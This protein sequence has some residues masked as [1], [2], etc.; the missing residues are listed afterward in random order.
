VDLKSRP[1]TNGRSFLSST[2]GWLPGGGETPSPEDKLGPLGLNTLSVPADGFANADLIF[3]HGLGGGSRKT[4]T[5]SGDPS[6]YWP[7]EWLPDDEALQDVRIHSF[8]YDSDWGK[9]SILSIHDFANGLLNSIL[10]CP[11]I[12]RDTKARSFSFR[13]I[14]FSMTFSYSSS[15][16][17]CSSPR[18]SRF[19]RTDA[20]CGSHGIPVVQSG[21]YY[22]DQLLILN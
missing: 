15:A 11:S 3:V 4:W 18:R 13:M 9:K 19:S 1:S 17:R 16:S 21:L 8:G 7:K 12:P 22:R 2:R 6:L 14:N 20:Q 10:D 5:K